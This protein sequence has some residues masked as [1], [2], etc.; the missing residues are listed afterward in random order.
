MKFRVVLCFLLLLGFNSLAFATN[1]DVTAT[2]TWSES[3]PIGGDVRS[4]VID[5]DDPNRLYL[6]TNDGQIYRSTDAA[7]TWT[8][9][10]SFHHPGYVVD[11]IIIDKKSTKTIYVPLWSLAND[12]DG[13][14]YKTTDG[15][16]T[17]Q[18][19]TGMRGHSVR[20]LALAPTD[21]NF[22]IA[23]AIDGAFRSLDAGA[24]WERFSPKDH[25]DLRRLHSIAIDKDPNIVYLG[26][27]HLPWR[28]D[29]GGK[30]WVCIKGHPTEKKQQFI[31]DSDIFTII[32][33]SQDSNQL[34]A[35]ACSGIYTSTDRASTWT[36]YQGIPF[37]SRRT[38]TI[39]PDP[40]NN[41]VI[42]SGTTEGL[43]KTVNGGQNWRLISSIRTVVNAVA[44]HPSNPNKVYVGVKSGGVLVSDNGG[45]SFQASNNGFVNRQISVLLADR[46]TPGRVYAAA[47]FNGFDGGLYLST[48]GGNTW[49]LSSRGL[50]SED[51]YTIYQSPW[52]EKL[53]F[54]G[55]NLGLYISSDRGESWTRIIN[56]L[57]AS[58]ITPKATIPSTPTTS[59]K[60]YT[61]KKVVAK[62]LASKG[63][64]APNAN[65]TERVVAL[66]PNFNNRGHLVAAWSGLYRISET[67][68][69]EKLKIA[70]YIGKILS[71]ATDQKQQIIYAGTNQGL[72]RSSDN[73]KA[74][75]IVSII[76]QNPIVQAVSVSPHDINIVMITTD[77][78]CFLTKDGGKTWRRRGGGIPYGDPIAVRFSNTNPNVILVGDYRNGGLYI[79]TDLGE[80]FTPINQQVPSNRIG[81]ISFDNFDPDRL[82]VGSFSGG[83]YVVRTPG[84]SASRG[85]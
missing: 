45:E 59:K 39:Y 6:G 2:F 50:A 49:Q 42:Y 65:I 48:D 60:T 70:N 27:E 80:S 25:P 3:G 19:L 21:S 32:V 5:K 82:Y 18:E 40:T 83:V 14:I 33:D 66:A 77:S 63:K 52:N 37:T 15:G 29:N 51:I 24:S 64:K 34:F 84:L 35:S 74:W 13:T 23:G 57:P 44:I 58:A 79:S 85:Q 30:D 7:K 9:L 36:K 41:Q 73:G 4:L 56:K 76:D 67:G 12:V 78:T 54:A 31:D 47:L 81:A 8:R 11:R 69:I 17:W 46:S 10:L 16:D 53:L 55:T 71:V 20:A 38:H 28:T 68:Q 43:W 62:T 72:Y 22:I 26:T 75:E 61:T 1:P